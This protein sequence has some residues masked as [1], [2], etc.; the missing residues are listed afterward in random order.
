MES[1]SA[2]GDQDHYCNAVSL[3]SKS[4]LQN[5]NGDNV[6]DQEQGA[7]GVST[8]ASPVGLMLQHYSP[9]SFPRKGQAK[10]NVV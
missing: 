2:V 4:V 3:H 5:E 6:C 7:S 1:S 8:K 10:V 9:Q